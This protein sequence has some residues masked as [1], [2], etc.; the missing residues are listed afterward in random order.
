MSLVVIAPATRMQQIVYGIRDPG[1][2]ALNEDMRTYRTFTGRDWR[3]PFESTQRVKS[4][5][6]LCAEIMQPS[7]FLNLRCL[8]M[9]PAFVLLQVVMKLFDHFDRDSN[10]TIDEGRSLVL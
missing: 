10:D 5:D 1:H 2:I 4:L 6:V 7:L 8:V 9:I 3:R